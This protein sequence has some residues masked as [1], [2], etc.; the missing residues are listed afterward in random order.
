MDDW[1]CGMIV[2]LINV[3]RGK[4]E[5]LRNIIKTDESMYVNNIFSSIC[6]PLPK[7]LLW[8]YVVFYGQGT[9]SP[10][11]REE[12]R[13]KVFENKVLKTNRE[14]WAMAVS[15]IIA[16]AMMLADD[17]VQDMSCGC[18]TK[19]I[20]LYTSHTAHL[21]YHQTA[22]TL[23]KILLGSSYQGGWDGWGM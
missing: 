8:S 17:V 10:T 2:I 12:H 9:W 19:Q 11:L 6:V 13:L 16:S 22:C 18:H 7:L 3:H 20:V 15:C 23:H 1:E 5:F 21:R 4:K 14:T